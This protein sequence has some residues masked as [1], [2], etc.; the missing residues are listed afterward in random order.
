MWDEYVPARQR[1]WVKSQFCFHTDSDLLMIDGHVVPAARER[2]NAA[3]VGWARWSKEEIG[4]YRPGTEEWQA[5]FGRLLGCRDPHARLTDM[6]ALGID[7]VMLFPTWFVRL[8]LLRDAVQSLKAQRAAVYIDAGNAKWKSAET[9]ASRLKQADVAAADG[10]SLNVSNYLTNALSISY[11]ERV[12]RLLGGKH[13]I[14]DTSRNG[15]GT[16]TTWCNARG[17]ALGVAPT[18]NT[19]HPLVDA[20]LWIKVPGESDGTCQGGPKAG[21]WWNEI[22]LEL[23]RAATTLASTVGR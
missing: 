11:G 9:M 17:Q 16:A 6:D 15:L 13:F 2:S 10:F 4:R 23:S 3:E 1:A 14:I 8:A 19:G 21:S 18:T 20:F 7:Q 22:A 5:R 12:S